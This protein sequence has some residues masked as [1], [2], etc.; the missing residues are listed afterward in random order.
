[1]WGLKDKVGAF[2]PDPRNKEG[3]LKEGHHWYC[4]YGLPGKHDHRNISTITRSYYG[5]KLSYLHHDREADWGL[6]SVPG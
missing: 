3:R 6:E 1:M 4:L 2:S 5:A